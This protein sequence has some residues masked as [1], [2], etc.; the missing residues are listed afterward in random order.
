MASAT[1]SGDVHGEQHGGGRPLRGPADQADPVP[2]LRCAWGIVPLDDLH[3]LGD[4]SG[5]SW[6]DDAHSAPVFAARTASARRASSRHSP[7]MRRVESCSVAVA[8]H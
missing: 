2:A 8:S 3:Y 5:V 1:T 7:M 4:G 6:P